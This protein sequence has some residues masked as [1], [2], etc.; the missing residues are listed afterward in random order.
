MKHIIV[1]VYDGQGTAGDCQRCCLELAGE[2]RNN[3]Q[4]VQGIAEFPVKKGDVLNQELYEQGKKKLVYL[5]LGEGFL[6]AGF[7]ERAL[8][9]NKQNK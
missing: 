5:A 3:E 1:D 2:G 8:R 7:T 6:D 4:L 9:I